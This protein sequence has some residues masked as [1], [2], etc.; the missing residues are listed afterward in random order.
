MNNVRQKIVLFPISIEE[1]ENIIKECIK[2]EIQKAV[3]PPKAED[4]EVLLTRKEAAHLL[5]ISLP[6]LTAYCKIGT[7]TSYRMGPLI[8]FKKSQ[9]LNSLQEVR[10]LKYLRKQL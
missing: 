4:E 3:K 8:R 6:T 7:I 1:L 9:L 2:T 10:S 5:G